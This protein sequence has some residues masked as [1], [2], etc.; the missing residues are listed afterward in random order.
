MFYIIQK[1]NIKYSKLVNYPIFKDLSGRLFVK[2][3]N[4][5]YIRQIG[6]EFKDGNLIKVNIPLDSIDLKT[7]SRIDSIVG[8]I[9]HYQDKLYIYTIHDGEEK[10]IIREIKK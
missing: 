5:Q 4:D 7:F 9:S 10:L 6:N 3:G 8:P 1:V 2:F